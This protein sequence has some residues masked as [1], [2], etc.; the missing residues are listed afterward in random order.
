[1]HPK[2]LFNFL[3]REGIT[4]YTGVPDSL[5][6]HF[7]SH[8]SEHVPQE[9]HVTAA[10]EGGAIALAAGY[11]LATGRYGLVYM[12]NSGLGNAVNPLLSLADPDVYRIPM[13]LLVGWRGEPEVPDEPQHVKQ[14][15]ITL[16]LLRTMGIDYVVLNASSDW[17]RDVAGACRIMKTQSRP[18]ALVA[19]AGAFVMQGG[20]S[21][22][23]VIAGWNP[24]LSREEALRLVLDVLEPK[25]IVVSTT[26]MLSR[27]LFDHRE[28]TGHS[29]TQDF[30]SIGSM[31]HASQIALGIALAR[32]ERKVYC[33]DG[34]GSVLMHGGSLAVVGQLRPNNFKH[35]VFNNGA[36]DSVGGQPSAGLNVQFCDWARSC[37]YT[38][39][40]L[41]VEESEVADGARRLKEAEGPAMLEIRVKTGARRDLG[42]PTISPSVAKELFM[43]G[44]QQ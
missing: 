34:D 43:R 42:R 44:L 9:L 3:T 36:H 14:G 39:A 28:A 22:R 33:L 23:R 19:R 27:E 6:K 7:C 31:G 11:H 13:L 16:E 12:Q 21:P 18:V 41:A 4:F 35:V 10:N 20:A 8:V 15:R 2:K 17:H 24:A 32:A 29:H 26:G 38:E 25:D 40:W 5:L 30:L 37:G 1:M